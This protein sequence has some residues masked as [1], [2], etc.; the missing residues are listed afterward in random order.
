MHNPTKLDVDPTVS[1]FLA[2]EAAVLVGGERA[3][4]DGEY[5]TGY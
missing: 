3:V 1:F 4:L 5:K 2:G